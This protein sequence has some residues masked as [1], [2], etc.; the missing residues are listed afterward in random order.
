MESLRDVKRRMA[1]EVDKGRA[2]PLE[3]K[4]I[5]MKNDECFKKEFYINEN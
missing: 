3:L 1:I 2:T 4:A 5:G